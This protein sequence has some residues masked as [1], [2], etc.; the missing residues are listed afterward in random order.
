MKTK[1]L[2]GWLV[3]LVLAT[4]VHAQP[5]K[6]AICGKMLVGDFFLDVDEVTGLTNK[7]CADC[8]KLDRC[9]VCGLPVKTGFTRLPDGRV[10]CARES[11][12]AV[13][14]DDE[15]KDICRNTR[16][17]LD[18]LLSRFM[19]F[20]SDNVEVSIVDKF[21]LQNLFF[22]P[23]FQKTCVTVNGAT[24]SNPLGNGKYLHTVDLLSCMSKP[25]LMA[26]CAHEYTHAWMGENV[27]PG[28]SAS[29]DR[30]TI[31]GFCELVA[32]KYMAGRQDASEMQFIRRNKYTKGKIDVLIAADSQYGFNAVVEWIKSGEDITLD[33]AN[34]DRVRALQ[35]AEYSPQSS[36]AVL[37]TAV[38]SAAPTVVPDTLRLKGISGTEQHRFAL[39]ND[40]TFETAEQERVRVGRTNV[41]VRCLEIRADSVVIQVNGSNQT[42]QLFLHGVR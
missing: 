17:D 42:Q 13:C 26:V 21:H 25:H 36:P 5:S 38:P 11:A 33:L 19:T 32:Y 8:Q 9:S 22:A 15:A 4:A 24:A 34:L 20:P 3:L 40:T 31:E 12:A 14:A 7:V 30:D 39:I 41:T 16:D 23:G 18:R 1:L 35:G 27:R 10:L 28:R 2:I 6:C 37:W 29:L